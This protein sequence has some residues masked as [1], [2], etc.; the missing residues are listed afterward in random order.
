MLFLV[1]ATVFCI[2]ASLIWFRRNKEQP[3]SAKWLAQMWSAD[4]SKTPHALRKG[5]SG[6]RPMRTEEWVVVEGK[7][8]FCEQMKLRRRLLDD[9]KTVDRF[10]ASQAGEDVRV[11]RAEREVLGAVLAHLETHYRDSHR[12]V[13]DSAGKATSVRDLWSGTTFEVGEY[14]DCPLKLAAKLVQ[15]DFILLDDAMTFVGGCALFS[16]MEIGLRGEKS[17]MDLGKTVKFIHTNVPN[18]NNEK[19]GI[20]AKVKRFFGSLKPG[21]PG[22]FRTNWLL[23]TEVGL[24]P[25]R[26]DLTTARAT[27]NYFPIDEQKSTRPEELNLRVEFQSITRLK[28]SGMTLF[29]LHTYS[30]PLPTLARAPKVPAP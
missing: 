19:N 20:G 26:Y 9:P 5:A 21:E 29:C 14:T 24:N 3:R 6:L 11:L 10:Y 18:F 8:T 1:L 17:N 12:V 27:E 22:F 16:F 28:E 7:N 4:P 30:D 15:E 23:V 2:V 25:M 13:R